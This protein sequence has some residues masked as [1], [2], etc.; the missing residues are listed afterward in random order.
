MPS[1]RPTRSP[2]LPSELQEIACAMHVPTCWASEAIRPRPS[3]RGHPN[4]LC[5][6]IRGQPSELCEGIRGKPSE[7]RSP[8]VH[9]VLQ[10]RPEGMATY[11]VA[12]R[13]WRP[14]CW[15]VHVSCN[16]FILSV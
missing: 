4:E 3:D 15:D 12:R 16:T 11:K 1:R 13:A 14:M 8:G 9:G 7:G 6:G 2:C 10:G 5:E